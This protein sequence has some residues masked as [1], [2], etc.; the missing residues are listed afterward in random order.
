MKNVNIA[1][2]GDLMGHET[3]ENDGIPENCPLP[4]GKDVEVMEKAMRKFIDRVD[5]GEVRSKKTYAEFK[6]ILNME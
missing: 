3:S 6:K 4:E 1:H 2:C 5:K